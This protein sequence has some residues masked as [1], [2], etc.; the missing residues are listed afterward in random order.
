[1]FIVIGGGPAG[2]FGAIRARETAPGQPVVLLEKSH[3]ALRKV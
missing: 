3:Q 2:F 1:M